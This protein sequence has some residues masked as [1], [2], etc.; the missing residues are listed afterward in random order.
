MPATAPAANSL[1][2][3]F[4]FAGT[5]LPPETVPPAVPS[6]P[7]TPTDAVA[8]V[9]GAAIDPSLIDPSLIDPPLA[10]ALAAIEPS[11]AIG[12]GLPLFALAVA[13]SPGPSNVVLL[14]VGAR[15]GVRRGLGLLFGMAV[16]YGLLWGGASS[17]LH[18]A[19]S[20]DPT[21]LRFARGAALLLMLLMAWKLMSAGG[22]NSG[23]KASDEAGAAG[24]GSGVLGGIAFQLLNPK[25]WVTAF[26]AAAL[27]LTPDLDAAGRAAW[28]GAVALIAVLL[29]CGA[30]LVLGR[31]GSGV[32]ARAPVQRAVNGLL[33]V[34]LVGS[35][36]PLLLA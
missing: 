16:G 8:V 33:A 6:A 23:N 12:V 32:L 14:S 34:A 9:P 30:W 5:V 15:T 27:F 24:A 28:F 18:A 20:L 17:G 13:A 29:G 19:A 11:T 1:A 26:A 35:G 4:D 25:A 22:R 10:A 3:L 21:L 31:I 7:A 36:A 2:P